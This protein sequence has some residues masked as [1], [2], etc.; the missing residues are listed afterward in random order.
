MQ[1][2]LARKA[3]PTSHLSRTP[4]GKIHAQP[5]SRTT[6]AGRPYQCDLP[7]R[8]G[9]DKFP[10]PIH[11]V[12]ITVGQ[13]TFGKATAPPQTVKGISAGAPNFVGKHRCEFPISYPS[14][15]TWSERGT[16]ISLQGC[17]LAKHPLHG[18]NARIQEDLNFLSSEVPVHRSSEWLH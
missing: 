4:L 1:N 3:E 14:R 8:V 18:R 10:A 17:I 15:E 11:G 5:R 9:A 13:P 12:S 16:S 6:E 7:L 2:E